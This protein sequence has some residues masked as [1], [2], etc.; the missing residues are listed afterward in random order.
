MIQA[1][2]V[3]IL[4]KYRSARTQPEREYAKAL[5]KIRLRFRTNDT[6][7]PGKPDLV[8]GSKRLVVGQFAVAAVSDRRKL[9]EN[10]TRRSETAA[11][12]V[13]MYHY[14][15]LAVFVDGDFRHD[16]P[17]RVRGSPA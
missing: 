9:L 1:V 4:G 16:H 11:T 3:P 17:W 15:S 10:K 2:K 13:K 8:F 7:L 12:A 5:R 6:K 14:Q